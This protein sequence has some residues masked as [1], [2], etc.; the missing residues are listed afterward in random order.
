M[1]KAKIIKHET[2][3]SSSS[4]RTAKLGTIC[5]SSSFSSSRI[6]F[7]SFHSQNPL[8][9]TYSGDFFLFFLN[10]F[11]SFSRSYQFFL[12]ISSSLFLFTS[13]FFVFFLRL[14]PFHLYILPLCDCVSIVYCSL[15]V[16][17]TFLLLAVLL[18]L[19]YL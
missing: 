10:F 11:S 4:N 2:I 12:C 14:F 9:A 19:Y 15:F 5:P 17:F 8:L 1:L 7:P 16:P 6:R 13:F 18:L 3:V